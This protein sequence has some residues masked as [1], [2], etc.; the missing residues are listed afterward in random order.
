VKI[1]IT[2]DGARC[3]SPRELRLW[4]DHAGRGRA[5]T[6]VAPVDPAEVDID[7]LAFV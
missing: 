6:V 3:H 7:P 1:L 2:S 4:E 5:R